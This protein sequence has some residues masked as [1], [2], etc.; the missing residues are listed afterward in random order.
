MTLW[1]DNWSGTSFFQQG[2]RGKM[3]IKELVE[4]VTEGN[5]DA[6][7]GIPPKK[8]I[9][10]TRAVFAQIAKTVNEASDGVVSIA[11][12]GQLRIRQIEREVEGKPVVRKQI[13]FRPA[14][15]KRPEKGAGKKGTSKE[16]S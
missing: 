4:Q 9:A 11:G 14:N 10:I 3:T 16:T 13:T 1:R 2:K 7:T 12:L 5:K 15:A 8:A 6:L